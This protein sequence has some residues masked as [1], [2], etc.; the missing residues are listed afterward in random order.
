MTN[1]ISQ[2]WSLQS[3]AKSRAGR[4]LVRVDGLLGAL[5]D[6]A[7]ELDREAHLDSLGQLLHRKSL[8]TAQPARSVRG[9]VVHQVLDD[10]VH[11]GQRLAPHG[12]AGRLLAEHLPDEARHVGALELP[13]QQRDGGR[14]HRAARCACQRLG[15]AHALLRGPVLL[16]FLGRRVLPGFPALAA[17]GAAARA[18]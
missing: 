9:E 5:H 7:A 14:Q 15:F 4:F 6:G 2:S 8:P 3:S 12:Q 11:L 18:G 10:G 13:R 16:G 17:V 1:E